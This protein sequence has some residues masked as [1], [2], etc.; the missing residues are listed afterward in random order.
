MPKKLCLLFI[1]LFMGFSLSAMEEEKFHCPLFK[2]EV[3]RL[4]NEQT[5]AYKQYLAEELAK[6]AR[7]GF[8][9]PWEGAYSVGT[10][11]GAKNNDNLKP[12]IMS[13]KK[14]AGGIIATFSF[15]P[16]SLILSIPMAIVGAGISTV[17]YV[18]DGV[19]ALKNEA[20]FKMEISRHLFQWME[21]VKRG[22]LAIRGELKEKEAKLKAENQEFSLSDASLELLRDQKFNHYFGSVSFSHEHLNQLLSRLDQTQNT[23]DNFFHTIS[24]RM[25]IPELNEAE[26]EK[27]QTILLGH[28][29]KEEDFAPL[30]LEDVNEYLYTA[31]YF[32]TLA[33]HKHLDLLKFYLQ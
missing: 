11:F 17:E 1:L 20:Q 3:Y 27:L 7:E 5:K 14:T 29:G 30:N 19:K 16:L 23:W 10:Y 25:K 12:V 21:L 22:R 33:N 6:G 2:S 9:V 24:I 8:F 31:I 28:V 13:E 4:I 18:M 26:W 32:F 15:S